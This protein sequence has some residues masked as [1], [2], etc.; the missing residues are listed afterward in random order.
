MSLL[1]SLTSNTVQKRLF[2]SLRDKAPK[3]TPQELYEPVFEDSKVYP[4]YSTINVR[5]QS[6]NFVPLEKYEGYV[7]R[8]A[9]KFKFEIVDCYAVAAQTQNIQTYKP[10]STVVDSEIE[11]SKYDRTV[12]ISQVP[13]IRLPLFISLIQTH[14]P[15]GIEITVKEHEKVDE[16]NRYIPDLML[17]EKQL[18]LK[19]LDDPAIRRNLGWE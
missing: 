9:K 18:E 19:A 14:A 2:A 15:I 4:E 12:R 11:L 17:K 3:I 7:H 13:S 1:K 6:Y 8:I 10:N 16:D 5:L